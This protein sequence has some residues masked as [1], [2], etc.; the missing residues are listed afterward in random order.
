MTSE[1][2]R[3]AVMTREMKRIRK[4]CKLS[5]PIR[6][7]IRCK[8]WEPT[9]SIT[10]DEQFFFLPEFKIYIEKIME[11][12]SVKSVVLNVKT[13][14]LRRSYNYY[15]AQTEDIETSSFRLN[16]DDHCI[17]CYSAPKDFL[18]KKY[19][20]MRSGYFSLSYDSFEKLSFLKIF[21]GDIK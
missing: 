10:T 7:L 9:P 13:T 15:G 17:C 19:P 20:A 11:L 8:R 14:C 3:V 12:S 2:L 5:F 1:E 21:C 18:W 4:E 16:K 6:Q